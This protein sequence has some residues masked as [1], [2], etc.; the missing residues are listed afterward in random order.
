[1]IGDTN[2]I[3]YCNQISDNFIKVNIG[4]WTGGSINNCFEMSTK[5]YNYIEHISAQYTHIYLCI[6]HGYKMINIIPP[7][8]VNDIKSHKNKYAV[9][10]FEEQKNNFVFESNYLTIN[11]T[12][13]ENN[14]YCKSIFDF[15]DANKDNIH[16]YN[17]DTYFPIV[18]FVDTD[19]PV[20]NKQSTNFALYMEKNIHVLNNCPKYIINWMKNNNNE[21]TTKFKNNVFDKIFHCFLKL[22][23]L[24]KKIVVYYGLY[25]EGVL[26]VNNIMF[27]IID[28]IYGY[29]QNML[30]IG[31][32]GYIHNNNI[33]MNNE[34][35]P[36]DFDVSSIFNVPKSEY[37]KKYLKYKYKYMMSKK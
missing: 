6:A 17:M 16:V 2:D 11:Y 30:F 23:N 31:W 9:F 5:I 25:Y 27:Y 33:V 28:C 22:N 19:K 12:T 37:H 26:F 3:N 35:K 36:M 13:E 10:L 15:Y 20:T 14:Q 34:K 18:G 24:D 8:I 29:C 7:F 4:N 1:M 21:A 32:D